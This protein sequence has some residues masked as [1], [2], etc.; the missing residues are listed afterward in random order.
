MGTLANLA[1]GRR[2]T[3]GARLL[4]GRS[5]ACPLHLDSPAV[6]AEHA[7]VFF[8]DGAW[9]IRD[10]GSTN[11]TRLDGDIL[12]PGR[13]VALRAGATVVFGA[14][15]EDL[16]WRLVDGAPPRPRARCIDDGSTA[17]GTGDLLCLPDESDPALTVFIDDGAWVGDFDGVARVLADQQVVQVGERAWLVE[18]PSVSGAQDVP[19]TQRVTAGALTLETCALTF[20]VSPDEEYVEVR[21]ERDGETVELP[22]RSFHYTLLTLARRRI[23]DA[24]AVDVPESEHGWVYAETLAEELG[25]TRGKLNLDV[26]RARQLFAS[27]GVEGAGRLIARRATSGQLRLGIARVT[28]EAIE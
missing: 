27:V 20:R 12:D 25:M 28:V 2:V 9:W 14:N 3:L 10:L 11:G 18:L 24:L 7:S 15:E 6:S 4:V 26:C 13:R 16:T 19:A 23:E 8:Q 22:P 21:L 5:A 1:A 17:E